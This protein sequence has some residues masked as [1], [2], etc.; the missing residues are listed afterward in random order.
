MAIA[1]TALDAGRIGVAAQ[2][3]GIAQA[4]LDEMVSYARQRKQ[5]GKLIGEFQAVQNMISDSATELAASKELIARAAAS[6][7]RGQPA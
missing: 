3:T 4:C 2:A 1:L 6:I 5:F 7:D